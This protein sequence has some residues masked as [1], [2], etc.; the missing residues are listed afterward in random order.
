MRNWM[1]RGS[2]ASAAA[3]LMLLALT[4]CGSTPPRLHIANEATPE[5]A[6]T[7]QTL[8]ARLIASVAPLQTFV[9]NVNGRLVIQ[10]VPPAEPATMTP[11]EKQLEAN[12]R[13]EYPGEWSTVLTTTRLLVKR[14]AGEPFRTRFVAEFAVQKTAF[15]LLSVGDQFWMRSPQAGAPVVTGSLDD[16]RPRPSD[17]PTA[18]PQDLGVLLLLDDLRV[19]EGGWKYVTFMETWPNY[20]IL[21]VLHPDRT[22][23]IIYSRIW[24]DRRTLNVVYHQLF[25]ANGTVV[26]EARLGS[27]ADFP[28]TPKSRGVSA[29]GET[30]GE[31]TTVSLPLEAVV[32]WPKENMALELRFTHVVLNDP[33]PNQYFAPPDVTKVRVVEMPSP[34]KALKE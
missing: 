30:P 29:R 21:H 28:A 6:V 8:E 32:F 7:R 4:G 22:P 3:G 5:A 31:R 34:P 13:Q 26:A 14:T 11:A 9:A 1:I 23:Q 18:R 12:Q 10:G 15:S 19:S 24:V 2:V 25:D 17:W 27:Y 20:Y 33:L 16:D